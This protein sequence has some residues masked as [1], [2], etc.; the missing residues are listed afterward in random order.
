MHI[1]SITVTIV[2]N[3][4]SMLDII[5]NIVEKKPIVV[6][7]YSLNPEALM[8]VFCIIMTNI[9]SKYIMIDAQ[10]RHGDFLND[11]KMIYLYIFCMAYLGG[12]DP[13]LALGASVL[14][15]LI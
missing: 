8:L 12:R 14:Y 9:G 10:K 2:Y 13:M 11:P 4:T 6:Y 7:M 15:G 3:A 5:Y 1:M